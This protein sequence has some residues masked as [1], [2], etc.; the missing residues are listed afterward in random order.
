MIGWG[1]SRDVG[2]AAGCRKGAACYVSG[3]SVS[4]RTRATFFTHSGH[5]VR[6]I[7]HTDILTIVQ[8]RNSHGKTVGTMS[9]TGYNL[10]LCI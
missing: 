7:I 4:L 2:L 9:K 3:G 8:P 6:G 1:G 10:S 5:F